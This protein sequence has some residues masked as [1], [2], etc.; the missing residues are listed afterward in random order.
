V[1]GKEVESAYKKYGGNKCTGQRIYCRT[2]I[3]PS[4]GLPYHEWFIE[5]EQ[6]PEEQ[7]G[8]ASNDNAMRKQNIYY[9]DLIV[10]IF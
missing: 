10:G 6:E 3:N 5:F 2:Q 8:F 7:I 1:I 4:S 9:D